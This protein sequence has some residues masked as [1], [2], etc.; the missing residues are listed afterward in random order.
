MTQPLEEHLQRF[1]LGA[2]RA[3]QRDVIEAVLAGRD[4][5]CIMPTGG[6]KSLC[7]QLPSIARQGLTLVISPLIALM[8]DQVDALQ[9][10]GIAADFIN[11]T[12]SSPEQFERMQRLEHGEYDLLYVAP[13]RFRSQTFLESLRKIG[14][15]LMAVDEAH[16]ISEWGHDFRH[17]YT[18]LGQFRKRIGNPQTIALTATA[19]PDVQQDVIAQLELEQPD[20]FV[21]GFARPNLYYQVRPLGSNQEK[22]PT[23]RDF[24]KRTPGAGIVYASTRKACGEVAENIHGIDQRRVAIYHAGLEGPQRKHVQDEFMSGKVDIIVATNA[25]GMGIDKPD[26]RFVVHYNMPGRIEAYYQEAGRAGRDGQPSTCLLLYSPADRRIQEYFINSAYPDASVVRE[27][28]EFLKSHPNDPIELTQQEIRD[29]L[30]LD[31]SNEGVGTCERLLEKSGVMKRLEPHRNMATVRLDSDLPT[32]VD[33]LPSNASVQRKVLQGIEK[34]VK[35]QRYEDVY[36]QPQ[37]LAESLSLDGSSIT[38]A[39]RSLC[40][41]NAFDYVPPFRGRAIHMM[42]HD[43][44]FSQ[45]NIDFQALAARKTIDLNKLDAMVRL[46]HTGRCRQHEI[47][48]YFGDRAAADCHNC[49]NCGVRDPQGGTPSGDSA[50]PQAMPWDNEHLQSIAL[51]QDPETL[52]A[53][54]MALSGVARVK[55]RCGKHLVAAM[56]AGSRSKKVTQNRLDQLSTHGRLRYLQ[57]TEVNH[58]LESL[59]AARLLQQNEI[60]QYR[61]VLV[62]TEAGLQVMRGDVQPGRHDLLLRRDVHTKM[63]MYCHEAAHVTSKTAAN[64]PECNPQTAGAANPAGPNEPAKPSPAPVTHGDYLWTLRLLRDGYTLEEC[65][66]IRRLSRQTLI[67][68]AIQ[69]ARQGLSLEP[70]L[71]FSNPEQLERAEELFRQLKQ[72]GSDLESVVDSAAL[73]EGVLPQHLVLLQE[74]L[75]GHR[76]AKTKCR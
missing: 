47:L 37:R 13:E 59:I 20:I 42:R 61:P 53:V 57:Q 17:D 19:T 66:E 29:T 10:K 60:N 46:V 71:F 8:K 34:I 40:E 12:L 36:F 11:S 63:Q 51:D 16:C 33:L 44:D 39:L 69:A 3:G 73:P 1:G 6:G 28:Y 58:L 4:C 76:R 27:V 31:I 56:L 50:S 14:V 43:L 25:F 67:E 41:L 74:L 5:L 48:D 23:L 45:L 54:Q 72:L 22:D 2:F 68:H 75:G 62:L 38:R 7:Y 30:Q 21:A 24:L 26:V 64:P 65:T 52:V 35:D 55:G 18:R 70:Q 15:T 32:L 9:Q 49:D